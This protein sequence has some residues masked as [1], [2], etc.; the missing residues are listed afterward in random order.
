MGK[1]VCV[2]EKV[3]DVNPHENGYSSLFVFVLP[4]LLLV[5]TFTDSSPNADVNGPYCITYC[6]VNPHA[7]PCVIVVHCMWYCETQ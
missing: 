4:G 6:S 1:W 2:Q 3:M 7:E 5:H